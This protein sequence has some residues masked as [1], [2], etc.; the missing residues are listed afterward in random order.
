MG[1]YLCT[2]TVSVLHFFLYKTFFIVNVFL[3]LA[4][5]G[6]CFEK[7]HMP[8]LGSSIARKTIDDNITS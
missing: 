6:E 2:F 8:Y 1:G 4:I 3:N 7:C 5:L